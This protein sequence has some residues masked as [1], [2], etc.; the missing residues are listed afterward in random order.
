MKKSD[1]KNW[2]VVEHRNGEKYVVNLENNTFVNEFRFSGIDSY[3]DDLSAGDFYSPSWDVIA[4]YAPQCRGRFHVDLHGELLWKRDDKKPISDII[5]R[6]QE[7][8]TE[9]E[10]LVRK[11]ADEY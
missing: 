8:N 3:N 11:L 10:S 4:V 1:L 2:M 6:I 7:L 5:T 9:M